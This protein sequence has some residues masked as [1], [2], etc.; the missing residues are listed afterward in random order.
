[1]DYKIFLGIIKPDKISSWKENDDPFAILD[2]TKD[3]KGINWIEFLHAAPN[4]FTDEVQVD[5]GSFAYKATKDQIKRL[6]EE[7]KAEIDDLDDLPDENLGAVFI[8]MS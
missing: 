7:H 5:W 8:E 2:N 6:I 4:I 1:M 3:I